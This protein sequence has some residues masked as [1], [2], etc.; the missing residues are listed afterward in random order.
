MQQGIV[1]CKPHLFHANL[2]TEGHNVYLWTMVVRIQAVT[3]C[4]LREIT[5]K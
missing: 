1:F 4:L 5:V 2:A 3:V